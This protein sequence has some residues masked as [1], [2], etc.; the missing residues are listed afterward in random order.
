MKKNKISYFGILI[1][2][3]LFFSSAAEAKFI[4]TFLCRIQGFYSSG[5]ETTLA[6][7][8]VILATKAQY[9]DINR[10]TWGAIHDLNGGE[11][12]ATYTEIYPY[13]QAFFSNSAQDTYATVSTN[14]IT[15]YD[16]N[17]G[18][19]ERGHPSGDIS[20][21]NPMFRLE[22]VGGGFLMQKDK[23]NDSYAL[24]F[25]NA[26]LHNYIIKAYEIDFIGQS[27]QTD[28][29]FSDLAL[30]Y[31]A[32]SVNGT[33]VLYTTNAEWSAAMNGALNAITAG[34][35][36]AGLKFACNRGLTRFEEG[37]SAWM[38]LDALSTPPD[39]VL[40]EGAFIV[41]WGADAW[42]FNETQ[43]KNQID[44]LASINNS[45]VLFM[46]HAKTLSPNGSCLDQYGQTVTSWEALWYSM[47]SFILGKKNN[48]YFMMR[49]AS[50]YDPFD[51]YFPEYDKIDLGAAA[52]GYKVTNY[53]GINIYWREFSYGYVYVNPT[54][55]DVSSIPLPETCKQRTHEN[56]SLPLENLSNI[57]TI[58]LNKRRAAILYKSNLPVSP[59]PPLDL[60]ILKD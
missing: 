34:M 49:Y 11:G 57:N 3:L 30:A 23:P 6:K 20:H 10:D 58:S 26:N 44:T 37:K 25:G 54:N 18:Y 22:K 17:V 59:R 32:G 27:W 48:S 1:C 15:R 52:G 7:Y 42:F 14:N 28:G 39:A 2:S 60:K 12:Y 36:A 4:N 41:M 13:K 8:D 43:W 47:G 5:D 31:N 21:D 19:G 45:K 24:D 40:E 35:H 9:N 16:K 55:Y 53:N 38:A 46:S 56:L 33:P 50:S 51:L 29:V